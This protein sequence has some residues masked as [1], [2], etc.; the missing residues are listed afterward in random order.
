MLRLLLLI[1]LCLLLGC[2]A[3]DAEPAS[4]A[5]DAAWLRSQLVELEGLPCPAGCSTADWAELKSGLGETIEARIVGKTVSSIPTI[6]TTG[7]S[8]PFAA[9]S[10]INV[11]ALPSVSA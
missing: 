11:T 9:W 7:N 5:H 2:A 6:K 8:N 10:V 1:S 4:A 3:K